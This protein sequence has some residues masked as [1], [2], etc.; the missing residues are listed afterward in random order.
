MSRSETALSSSSWRTRQRW[1]EDDARAALTA[2][3]RSGLSRARFAVREGVDVQRLYYWSGRLTRLA[4]NRA[5][6]VELTPARPV[7]AAPRDARF[8]VVLR[9]GHVVRV[10]EM[11]DAEA[12][13][14]LLAALGEAVPC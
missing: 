3:A 8:E 9:S 12:L 1:T 13:R 10:G 2:Q 14:R 4:E 5:A 6:F 11:F 7:I